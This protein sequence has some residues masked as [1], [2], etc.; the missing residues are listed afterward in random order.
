MEATAAMDQNPRAV[1][2][3][4]KRKN[5]RRERN[6]GPRLRSSQTSLAENQASN[7]ASASNWGGTEVPSSSRP[8]RINRSRRRKVGRLRP[9]LSHGVQASSFAN[10]KGSVIPFPGSRDEQKGSE[11]T[12]LMIKNIPC[13]LRRSDLLLKL[14]EHCQ[15][16][17]KKA[18]SLQKSEINFFY[19][20]LDFKKFWEKKTIANLG[21]AFV[22]FTTAVG[23]LRF[24]ARYD[25]SMWKE[26]A[27]STKVCELTCA[28]IQGFEALMKTFSGRRYHGLTNEFFPV[29]LAPACDGV[30]ESNHI[31]VGRLLDAPE[32]E[33]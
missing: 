24:Y 28:K 19:L 32:I 21:Y 27:Q 14:K 22:N 2:P 6:M 3:T 7:F 16:E 8:G 1:V 5:F 25:K 15:E 17:N 13:K 23:A 18:D 10:G 33:D 9:S 12:T 4:R 11:V 26:V 29:I 30:R 20:P 31:T